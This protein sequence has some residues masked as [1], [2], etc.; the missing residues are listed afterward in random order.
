M[1]GRGRTGWE[2]STRPSWSSGQEKMLVER[3]EGG[4]LGDIWEGEPE[5]W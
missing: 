5:I 1:E 4:R 3:R 2:D